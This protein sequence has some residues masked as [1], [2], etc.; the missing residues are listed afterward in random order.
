MEIEGNS[1]INMM[2]RGIMIGCLSDDHGGDARSIVIFGLSC[3]MMKVGQCDCKK[4]GRWRRF[5][6]LIT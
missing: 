5:V 2:E 4:V 6:I 1:I 3:E